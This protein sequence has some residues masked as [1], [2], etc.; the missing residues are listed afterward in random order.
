[1]S[2][3]IFSNRGKIKENE[4]E[5]YFEDFNIHFAD[6]QMNPDSNVVIIR[7]V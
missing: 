1:M 5:T 4:T 6:A 7:S 3:L 2:K